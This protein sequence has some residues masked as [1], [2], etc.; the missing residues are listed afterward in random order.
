MSPGSALIFLGSSF[1]GAGHNAVP[2]SIRIMHSLFFIRGYFRTEENQF[3]TVPHSK[4][5]KMSPKMLQ[6]LGY[7][8]PTTELGIVENISPHEDLEGIRFKAMQ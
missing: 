4:I 5:R 8:K 3:L 6:L 1:H 2:N 7:V